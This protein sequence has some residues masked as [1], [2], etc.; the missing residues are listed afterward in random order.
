MATFEQQFSLDDF[1]KRV[2][3]AVNYTIR[4][5]DSSAATFSTTRSSA[6]HSAFNLDIYAF[7]N[8]ILM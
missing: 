5:S 3:S 7:D 8:G 4:L 1:A 2:Y 6:L